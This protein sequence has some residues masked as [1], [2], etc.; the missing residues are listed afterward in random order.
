MSAVLRCSGLRVPF[1]LAG[2]AS[3]SSFTY[4][5]SA[6]IKTLGSAFNYDAS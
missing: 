5:L 3:D 1:V 4:M 2:R 6:C